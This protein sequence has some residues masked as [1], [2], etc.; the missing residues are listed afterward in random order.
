M[1]VIS[2]LSLLLIVRVIE[3]LIFLKKVSKI[4]HTYDWKYIDKHGY[5]LIEVMEN[6]KYYMTS[7]WSAYNFLFIKG[8][9]PFLMLFSLKPLR[10]EKQYNKEAVN[11]LREYE[12][13]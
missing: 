3:L 13:I 10:V 6:D 8:P 9:N 7:E 1:V 11:K 5:P 2:M 4:C 12:V